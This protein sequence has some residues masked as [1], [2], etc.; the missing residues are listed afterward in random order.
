MQMLAL[1]QEKVL[2]PLRDQL[3]LSETGLDSLCFAV[4]AARLEDLLGVDP[5]AGGEMEEFPTTFGK[6][7]AFYEHALALA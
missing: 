4:L 1:E 5:F 2:A 3:P 6:L 7:V